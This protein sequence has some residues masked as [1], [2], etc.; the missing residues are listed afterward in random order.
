LLTVLAAFDK[1]V[2]SFLNL[3]LFSE[4]TSQV[5]TLS[6]KEVRTDPISIFTFLN[7]KGY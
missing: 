1:E 6:K 2:V 5:Y 3:I 7:E 4:T